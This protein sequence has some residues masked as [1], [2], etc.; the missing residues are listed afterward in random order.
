MKYYRLGDTGQIGDEGEKTFAVV[1]EK[2]GYEV[3]TT[4]K[5]VDIRQHV[6]LYIRKDTK[7]WLRVDV[8]GNKRS[9]RNAENF[10][11]DRMWIELRNVQ[12]RPGWIDGEADIIAQIVD[13]KIYIF[14][15]ENLRKWVYSMC[16]LDL[17][18]YHP[19][20]A[21]YRAYT[22]R[23]RRDLITMIKLSDVPPGYYK[24]WQ[25]T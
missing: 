23:G 7:D 15:R 21:L 10:F 14:N 9:V 4:S 6:D 24:V 20:D 11:S 25:I 1:A 12:G 13:D 5:M 3:S 2:K 16:N 19:K 22:R 8:K 18:V 17:Q